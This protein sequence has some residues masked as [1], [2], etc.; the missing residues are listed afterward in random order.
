MGEIMRQTLLDLLMPPGHEA[1]EKKLYGVVAGI[2]TNNEDPDGLG[3]V[4]IRFPW[5]SE[6]NESWWARIAA[7]MAGKE[8]G[9]YFLPEVDDEVLV[10]FEH[11][12]VNFP[13]VLG[14]LWNG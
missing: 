1:R 13:Y 9:A 8:R 10:A 3:R 7:P 2:V 4:K 11:G 5:L 14:A 6:D 12:D